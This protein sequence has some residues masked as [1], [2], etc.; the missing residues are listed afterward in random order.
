[1]RGMAPF[2][3]RECVENRDSCR[4]FCKVLEVWLPSIEPWL[5]FLWLPGEPRSEWGT[6]R[7]GRY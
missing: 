5:P 6:S 2:Y 3:L 1:M 4:Y 7:C